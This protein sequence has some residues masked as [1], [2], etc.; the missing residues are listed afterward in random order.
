MTSPDTPPATGRLPDASIHITQA[1]IDRYAAL[2]G[3]F[4]PIHVDP[5]AGAASAFGST[6]AHG[7]IPLEPVF[8]SLLR[9]SGCDRLPPRTQVRL[10]YRAPSRPG[11]T[12]R[13][14]VW[15]TGPATDGT[16]SLA[17]RCLNQHG[18]L[19]LDGEADYPTT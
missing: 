14:E 15:Q 8:Q 18:Q 17:F 2:S 13:A 16:Q 1:L 12:V 4:N 9:W 19:V 6:I 10:R 7:C 11:D 5:V 3:D